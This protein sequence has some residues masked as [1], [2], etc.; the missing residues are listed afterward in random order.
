MKTENER[1]LRLRRLD[2]MMI[3]GSRSDLWFLRLVSI[4]YSKVILC[5]RVLSWA[6]HAAYKRLAVEKLLLRARVRKPVVDVALL[7]G[8]SLTDAQ[9]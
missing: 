3:G 7:A 8:H 5:C 2:Q 4:V 6:H 1:H 9:S